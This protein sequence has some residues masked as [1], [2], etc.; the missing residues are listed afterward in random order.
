M[1]KTT[2][3]PTP[4]WA[5]IHETTKTF[6]EGLGEDGE[7]DLVGLNRILTKV[8]A[9]LLR[10]TKATAMVKNMCSFFENNPFKT[11]TGIVFSS[12]MQ[13]KIANINTL[14]TAIAALIDESPHMVDLLSLYLPRQT[15]ARI[16]AGN[17][18]YANG[19]EVVQVILDNV[20]RSAVSQHKEAAKGGN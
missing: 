11:R 6:L 18:E 15:E 20:N 1:P 7:Y 19:S 14:T 8:D 10:D 17:T 12:D 13:L 9:G 16:K 4:T 5:E 3:T 2:E